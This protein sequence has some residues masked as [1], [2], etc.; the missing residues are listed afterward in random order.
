MSTATLP[1]GRH[2]FDRAVELGV[3][4]ETFAVAQV[5][6]SA[7]NPLAALDWLASVEQDDDLRCAYGI[8]AGLLRARRG[9]DQ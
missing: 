9:G 6:H 5:M 1:T 4:R 2:I 7:D 3:T 8:A